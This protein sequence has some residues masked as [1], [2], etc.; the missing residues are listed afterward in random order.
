MFNIYYVENRTVR[1]FACVHDR[2]DAIYLAQRIRKIV[3]LP[4]FVGALNYPW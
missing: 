1:Y 3:G 2:E 4:V